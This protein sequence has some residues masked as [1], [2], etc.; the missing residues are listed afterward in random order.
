MVYL[1]PMHSSELRLVVLNTYL[2]HFRRKPF[3][4]LVRLGGTAFAEAVR[5]DLCD[6]LA[7][8]LGDVARE[9]VAPLVDAM[10]LENAAMWGLDDA[11]RAVRR[12]RSLGRLLDEQRSC[13]VALCEVWHPDERELVEPVAHPGAVW[14]AGAGLLVLPPA[15]AGSIVHA[16]HRAFVAR[17]DGAKDVDFYTDKGVQLARVRTPQGCID[18]YATHLHDGGGMSV[19]L[20]GSGSF[21][22]PFVAALRRHGANIDLAGPSDAER[23]AVRRQQLAELARFVEETRSPDGTVLVVGD[24]NIDGF[25]GPAAERDP[26]SAAHGDYGDLAEVLAAARWDDVALRA[27][28]GAEGTLV[29]PASGADTRLRLDYV[30]L[31]QPTPRQAFGVEARSMEVVRW[32]DAEGPLSDHKALLVTLRCTPR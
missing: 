19:V 10:M 9:H 21:G 32:S 6:V 7:G 13:L 12:A 20:G 4:M 18:L 31:E 1:L 25:S 24:L 28:L 3:D 23:R 22:E 16:D 29:D 11:A 17:G 14:N 27:G 26:A 15:G 5:R 8:Q 2:P 30:L